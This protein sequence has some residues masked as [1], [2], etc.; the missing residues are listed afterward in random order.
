MCLLAVTLLSPFQGVL[1][2]GGVRTPGLRAWLGQRTYPGVKKGRPSRPTN[3]EQSDM[4]NRGI[5]GCIGLQ[6]RYRP[7]IPPFDAWR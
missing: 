6:K 1:G 2:C 4:Q 3:Y 5:K 7:E